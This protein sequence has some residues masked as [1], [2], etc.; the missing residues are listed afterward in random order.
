MMKNSLKFIALAS[1]V[2]ILISS[3]KKEEALPG[4]SAS[5]EQDGK[6]P[7][8]AGAVYTMDNSTAGNNILAF[9]RSQNGTLTAA[10]T[11]ATGGTGTGSGLGSQGS[12]ILDDGYLYAVNAGSNSIS[13]L[14]VHGNS[15]TLLDTIASGGT[16]PISITVDDGFVYV[17]NAGGTGNITGFVF[18]GDSLSPIAGSTQSLSSS[19]ADP[20]QIQFN[21]EGTYLFVTEKMTNMITTY[22]VDTTGLA[23]PGTSYPST[24]T[25]PFG[26]EFGSNNVLIVS[27]AFGGAPN[28]SA[29]TSYSYSDTGSISLISGPVGTNQTAACWVVITNNGKY[30]YTTNTGSNSITGY[31]I[32]NTGVLTLLDPSGITATTG[33]APIDMALSNNSRYLYALNSM[34][35]DIS[36]YSVMRD[37]SLFSLGT[38]SGLP[39]GSVGL[40][41]K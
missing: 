20:A 14:E 10:G 22:P 40:A 25:T 13:V 29:M 8:M 9:K 6:R 32:S 1:S 7:L 12:L 41:A 21:P 15:I 36:I 5:A 34:S 2:L 37:G 39:A 33:T 30:T 38:E 27:D 18:E 19:T 26:F 24:G 11:F 31:S 3:C 4:G 35:S 23:G 28:Q 16:K 17:L